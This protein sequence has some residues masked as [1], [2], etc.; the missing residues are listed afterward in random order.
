MINGERARELVGLESS[1]DPNQHVVKI[2]GRAVHALNP[3][4]GVRVEAENRMRTI[5]VCLEGTTGRRDGGVVEER[6]EER[7]VLR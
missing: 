1:N 7:T 5:E 4:F 6:R 2:N 3:G